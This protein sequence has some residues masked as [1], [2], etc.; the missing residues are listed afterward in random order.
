MFV[1]LTD[2]IAASELRS[3]VIHMLSNF[4]F[5]PPV[6]QSI[7]IVSMC[8]IVGSVGYTGLSKK[9]IIVIAVSYTHMTLPTNREV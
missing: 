6:I 9:L 5:L 1:E 3:W 8:V 4:S 2:W 7:H